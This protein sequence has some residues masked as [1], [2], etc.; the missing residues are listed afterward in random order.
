LQSLHAIAIP[1][2]EIIDSQF[3]AVLYPT[4]IEYT[5]D[6]AFRFPA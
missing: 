3:H 4:M 2:G 5:W 6:V 1:F